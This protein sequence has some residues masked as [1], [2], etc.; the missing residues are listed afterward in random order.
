MV[1]TEKVEFANDAILYNLCGAQDSNIKLIEKI[2]SVRLGMRGS[3]LSISGDE[4]SVIHVRNLLSQ[5]QGISSKGY[6]LFP[7]DI[8]YAH[9][10]LSED[11]A[12][13]LQKIFLDTVFISSKKRI[14]SPKSIAQKL[15]IDA[16]R[17]SD[18]V[19]G[20]GPAGT[21]K[22]YLAMAM[23]VA[24]LLD[25][26]VSRISLARPAVEAGE[27]L[28]FLPGDLAEKVNPYLRP[29]YDAL[30]DM[31]DYDRAT[32]LLKKGVIEVAPLAFMRGRTL[33]ESFVILDE[34][35]NT[36]TEQMKMFLTRLGY[37]SKAVITGDITQ[38]D[39]P[40]DKISG[41]IEA[42]ELLY[43]TDGIGFVHFSELDVVRHPL[44]QEVI[45]AYNNTDLKNK[46][47]NSRIAKGIKSIVTR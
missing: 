30:F 2:C 45:R 19:F 12:A 40:A 42:E 46:R 22:T 25:Q 43:K 13:D 18:M 24:A 17:K 33:N 15:Y 34:A 4:F 16:I 37:G 11:A 5:L 9:R 6:P 8:E 27:K 32:V 10:I 21:G 35:Q 31:L 26:K 20:I 1:I 44:V 36:T 41:L 38:I 28:G 14:I 7:S 23:A 29:L 39:L 3:S 47:N